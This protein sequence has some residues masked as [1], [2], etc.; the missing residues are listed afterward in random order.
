MKRTVAAIAIALAVAS[1]VFVIGSRR[2]TATP[3]IEFPS[4]ST[5]CYVTF[6]HDGNA[7]V[8]GEMPCAER[9]A[10]R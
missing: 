2:L 10:P 5:R 3:Q 1:M 7:T 4:K 8:A 6:T 9:Q